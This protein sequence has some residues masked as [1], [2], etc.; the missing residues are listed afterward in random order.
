[1]RL[2]TSTPLTSLDPVFASALISASAASGPFGREGGGCDANAHET[3][4]SESVLITRLTR[5]SGG[6]GARRAFSTPHGCPPRPRGGRCPSGAHR[7]QPLRACSGEPTSRESDVGGPAPNQIDEPPGRGWTS[8]GRV[9]TT[10]PLPPLRH[11]CRSRRPEPP[12]RDSP[13]LGSSKPSGRNH[14]CPAGSREAHHRSSVTLFRVGTCHS[15][16]PA[17]HRSALVPPLDGALMAT[18]VRR[19]E[20]SPAP[21]DRVV[22][23]KIALDIYK[24]RK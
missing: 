8:A 19:F 5:P 11:R 23:G 22:P 21:V 10:T 18:P 17:A 14:D 24:V 9:P 13:G 4:W 20:L 3:P 12:L 7:F 16:C 15:R 2:G 1:M 6:E